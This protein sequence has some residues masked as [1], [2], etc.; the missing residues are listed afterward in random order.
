MTTKAGVDPMVQ[1]ERLVQRAAC[2]LAGADPKTPL[3]APLYADLHGLPPLLVQVGTAET[4]L[5]DATPL[6]DRA[7]AAGVEISLEPWEDMIH[8]WQ[9]F[10]PM[11]PESQQAIERIGDFIRKPAA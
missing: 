10:A 3:A 11:R 4:L 8:V 1:R 9:L 2:Y 5:D 6:A 7:R